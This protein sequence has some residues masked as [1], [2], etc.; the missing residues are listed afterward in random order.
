MLVISWAD[1]AGFR[2]FTKAVRSL[3]PEKMHPAASRAIN[4]TGDMARTEVRRALI[5]QTGL[6]PSTIMRAVH[7]SRSVPSTLTYVMR[8][9]GGDISLKYFGARETRSGVSAAPFGKRQVFEGTFIKGGRFP[10]RVVATGLNGHVFARTG[11]FK[12]MDRGN[13]A[14]K[15]RETVELQ[16]SGVIIPDEM[17]TGETRQAFHSTVGRVLPQRIAHEIRRLTGG[18]VT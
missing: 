4:R 8:A 7:T 15:R 1:D 2:R 3:G 6:K 18:V 9:K 17:I 10:N 14:G 13:Y 11:A 5:R 16:D 12:V